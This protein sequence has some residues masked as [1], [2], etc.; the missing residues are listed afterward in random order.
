[1]PDPALAAARQ[2][3]TQWDLDPVRVEP[4]SDAENIVFRVVDRDAAAFV[5]RLHRPGYHSLEELIAEHT[6]TQ[7]L[8]QAGIDAPVPR[9]TRGGAH[10]ATTELA[11]VQRYVGVLEW[12]DGET[13]ASTIERRGDADFE[14]R[15]FSTIGALLATLHNQATRWQVP[16]GFVRPALNADGFMG[17][18]PFWGRFWKS[19][20]VPVERRPCLVRLRQRIRRILEAYGEDGATYSLIHADLHPGNVV[21]HGERLHLIDFDD[22][23]FG[24]HVY[25]IAVALMSHRESPAFDR[26]TNA[27]V[28][29]Y[30]QVRPLAD[31]ALR[32]LPLFM[33]VRALAWL[34]W[35]HDRQDL[36]FVRNAPSI[37]HYV[38][39]RAEAVLAPLE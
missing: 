8:S 33:L 30:R 17:D 32:M 12:V 16:S 1:M 18:A 39:T 4:V 20:L 15:S 26:L 9:L 34:G 36:A 11:G 38:C 13:M 6:W 25:D 2:A 21:V 35:M 19:D 22:A 7:V 5:L 28:S 10:Y 3:L 29:G 24:W 31:A 27:L 37:L 23:A 14:L